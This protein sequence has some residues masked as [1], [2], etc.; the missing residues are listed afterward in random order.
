MKTAK[1]LFVVALASAGLLV[2]APA[3][4][5]QEGEGSAEVNASATGEVNANASANVTTP[6]PAAGEPG[7]LGVGGAI[8]LSGLAGLEITYHMSDKLMLNGLIGFANFSPD[9]DAD[10]TTLI[11]FAA[12]A[13]YSLFDHA[14]AD[15][16][17]GGRLGFVSDSGRGGGD[18]TNFLIELPLRI[19]IQLH[20]RLS[21]HFETGLAIDFISVDPGMGADSR[22]TTLIGLGALAGGDV[23]ATGGFTIH[24]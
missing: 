17:F 1:N 5:A 20:R 6:A 4:F 23:F 15:L 16:Y 10:S 21:L 18:L 19:E 12:S 24:F 9:G 22:S 2:A 13:F 11:G 3:A 7:K 14:W 8:T